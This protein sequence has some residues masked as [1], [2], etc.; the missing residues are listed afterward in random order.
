M[1][2]AEIANKKE[3]GELKIKNVMKKEKPEMTEREEE[4]LRKNPVN[5][6]TCDRADCK[7][8][9]PMVLE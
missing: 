7:G 2:P 1:T 5:V 4:E 8:K 9:D 6:F 3:S